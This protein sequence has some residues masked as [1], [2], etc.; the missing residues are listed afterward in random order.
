MTA[1]ELSQ[2]FT[3]Q[4]IEKDLYDWWEREGYFR[5][6]KQEELGLV[7]VGGPR[8]CLTLPPPNITGVLHLGHAIVIALEDLMCRF[9][10]M[11]GKQTLF[12]PGSDHAGIATQN[13]VERELAK[14]KISRKDLG[15]EK[16][17]EKVWEWKVKYHAR[18]TE[19][20]KRLGMSSDW[21][22][23]RFTLDE[24]LS[25]AV[26]TAFVTLYKKKL[27]YKGTYMVNW[28]P[29]CESAISDLEAEPEDEESSL[30]FLKYPVINN[31]WSGPTGKWGSGTWAKGA[32]E[33]IIL[34]TTRP[35]TLLGD[36]AVA[37]APNHPEWGMYVGKKVALPVLGREIPVIEDSYVD[38]EFGTGALKI[39][40]AHDPADYEIGK[41]H[42]LKE[43]AVIDEK[44]KMVPEIAGPYAGQDRY[45]C[46]TAIVADLKKEGLLTKIQP[47]THA[48]GHCQRCHTAIEPRIST[49]WFVSTKDLAQAA[50]LQVRDH[51]T[52]I[53]PER[54]E[55]RFWQWMDN[56]KDWC[57]SRQLWWGHQI[58][59]WYCPN[60][61]MICEM[62]D[63][64]KCPECG[65]SKLTRDEDVLDTWFSSGLWPFSTLGWPDVDNPDFKRYYPTDMRETAYDILFFW[66]AREMM[67]GVEL[68]HKTPYRT[69]Y[70]HG[71]VRNEKG[72][73]ISKSMENIEQYDP[74]KII[75]EF[76]ADALRFTLV[77]NSVPGQDM[78]LDRR[79]IDA[80]ARFCNKIWQSTK[81]A[82]AHFKEGEKIP[83]VEE[84]AKTHQ[85]HY[86]DSWIL[87]RVNRLVQQTTQFVEKYDYLN[88]CRIVKN[89]YWAE[90]CDW[91]IELSK[92]RLYGEDAPD[93]IVAKATLCYVLDTCF[94][95]LHPFM[96]FITEYLWQ[97]LPSPYKKVPALIVAQWP[98]ANTDLISDAAD[99]SLNVVKDLIEEIRS[100][101]SAFHCPPGDRIA[102]YIESGNNHSFIER[103]KADII[104]LARI[105]SDQFY[106]DQP[107]EP[108]G[109][110]GH[111]VVHGMHV[112]VSLGN[113]DIKAEI[114]RIKAE[115][116]ELD[117]NIEKSEKLLRGQ[118]ASR[119][120][121]EIVQAEREKLRANQEKRQKLSEQVT[122]IQPAK[123]QEKK[124]SEKPSKESEKKPGDSEEPSKRGKPGN[125]EGKE[126]KK[127][128][129]GTKPVKAPVK[130]PPKSKPKQA[131][132]PKSKPGKK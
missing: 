60:N 68:T 63:P 37:T 28:C 53:I 75:D 83:T 81:F 16:F 7:N 110:E 130:R 97:R 84:I 58:P 31:D 55:N 98:I 67:M 50:L 15:R 96:P 87:S 115:I 103:G 99:E 44:G 27:I 82:L 126:G 108:Q 79:H 120:P 47:Y 70:C 72:L 21:T 71:I 127:P 86:T 9:E 51:E 93:K 106:L 45:V 91:Y 100:V 35:E 107:I 39:T 89:F 13:V 61:H 23:E 6:E 90:L 43:I 48:V 5:P 4:D 116:A 19:Q 57:I 10:R 117:G 52:V 118:F 33:F 8:F 132:K 111:L 73:K 94:R 18:I 124:P 29:R 113:I 66:V 128:G 2:T 76:G 22:R 123:K 65:S 122:I 3:P 64:T 69:V 105:N 12:L 26:R 41:R 32:T 11:R 119:A 54:E 88:A 20:S 1:K 36:T 49:Q 129:E 62:E 40:P 77:A 30:W 42:G 56:I 38:P 85:F 102:I 24:N 109:Q 78:N 104:S 121:P 46:R 112:R 25:K 131:S 80:A 74:L 34:A 59:V 95:L 14:Q 92:T 101:R 114:A 125:D 17:V